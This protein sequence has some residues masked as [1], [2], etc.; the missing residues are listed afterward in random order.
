MDGSIHDLKLTLKLLRFSFPLNWA[1]Y[2]TMCLLLKFRS[3]KKKSIDSFY[4]VS[5]F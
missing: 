3:K 1:G 2:L 4:E 5:L